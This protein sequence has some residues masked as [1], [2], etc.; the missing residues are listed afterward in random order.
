MEP[1]INKI[2]LALA[3][4]GEPI[5]ETITRVP[6]R[7]SVEGS[8]LLVEAAVREGLAGLLYQRLRRDGQFAMLVPQWQRRLESIYYLTLRTNLIFL[9]VLKEINGQGVPF[10]VMQGISLLAAAY[11][12]PGVRPLSDIDLWV[13]PD[14]RERLYAALRR[15][16]FR[17]AIQIPG[18]FQRDSILIDVHAELGG[19]ERIG[20]RRFI[21]STGLDTIYEACRRIGWDQQELLCLD[22]CDQVVYLTVHA[23]KHN[24]ERLVWLA[25]LQRLTAGWRVAEWEKLRRRARQLG[26]KKVLAVLVYLRQSLFGMRTPLTACEQLNLTALDRYLLR[27]R[28]RGPLPKWSSL[29]LLSAGRCL[30]RIE[31]VLE[32]MFPRPEILRQVFAGR[33]DLR[34]WQLYGLRL[35][36]LLG[37]LRENSVLLPVQI[38]Q[39]EKCQVA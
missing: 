29:A 7:L 11:P 34:D 4:T 1:L 18:L 25:D 12:D 5:S 23:I 39:A 32:S 36:Q 6:G 15:L 26:Q 35:R 24:L 30:Q 27:I 14:H 19:A 3:A 17:E 9:D 31:F 13:H 10:V 37:M 2:L 16:N 8:R 21:F 28:K 20:A 33:L 38:R 22:P